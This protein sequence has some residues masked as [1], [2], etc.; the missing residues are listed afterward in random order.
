MELTRINSEL[1]ELY[2]SKLQDLSRLYNSLDEQGLQDYTNPLLLFCHEGYINSQK[3]II[4]IGQETNKWLHEELKSNKVLSVE[5]INNLQYLYKDFLLSQSCKTVFWQF[6]YSINKKICHE[7]IGYMWSNV[8]KIG[9]K[10][11]KEGLIPEL[12]NSKTTFSTSEKRNCR[13]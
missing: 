11:A 3:R 9:K 1:L 5:T 4:F 8:L 13:Y 6:I 10:Q 2:S 12:L 7:R